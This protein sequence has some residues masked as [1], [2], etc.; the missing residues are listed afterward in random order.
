M[1]NSTAQTVNT[2]IRWY[3]AHAEAISQALPLTTP[4]VTFGK[5]WPAST[6]EKQ[7]EL[8]ESGRLSPFLAAAYIVNPL[9]TIKGALTR[10]G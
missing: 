1:P 2:A 5:A 4:G 8:W 10:K 6:L 9:R 7:I 3:R